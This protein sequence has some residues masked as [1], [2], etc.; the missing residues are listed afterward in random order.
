MEVYQ[1]LK[2]GIKKQCCSPRQILEG[3]K[4]KIIH[5]PVLGNI[6]MCIFVWTSVGM[7]EGNLR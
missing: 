6:Y 3:E 5:F 1:A 4:K 7:G 2:E